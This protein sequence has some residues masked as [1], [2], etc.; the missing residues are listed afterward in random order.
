VRPF[1][2]VEL[3][4]NFNDK[5]ANESFEAS[6]IIQ[7][8]TPPPA[9]ELMPQPSV[10]TNNPIN[11]TQRSM[12]DQTF[13]NRGSFIIGSPRNAPVLSYNNSPSYSGYQPQTSN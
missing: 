11:L 7:Q 4:M 3:R 1:E 5:T 6:T 10:S 12:Q 8:V 2:S 13:A 9:A